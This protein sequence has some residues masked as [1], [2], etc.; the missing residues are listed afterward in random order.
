MHRTSRRF[1]SRSHRESLEKI[2]DQERRSLTRKT[3]DKIPRTNITLNTG[4]VLDYNTPDLDM[5]VAH[6]ESANLETDEKIEALMKRIDRDITKYSLEKSFR[7]YQNAD[8]LVLLDVLLTYYID[9]RDIDHY[10]ELIFRRG[11]SDQLRVFDSIYSSDAL[12]EWEIKNI[13][14]NSV[15]CS[16]DFIDYIFGGGVPS[17]LFEYFITF[18]KFNNPKILKR[19]LFLVEEAYFETINV[20]EEIKSRYYDRDETWK[21]FVRMWRIRYGIRTKFDFRDVEIPQEVLNEFR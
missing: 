6:V 4:I 21:I 2:R 11:N 9:M 16:L 1:D 17:D 14:H 18:E 20:I 19:L 12:A 5:F 10:L 8:N 15:E 7:L 3:R 13:S